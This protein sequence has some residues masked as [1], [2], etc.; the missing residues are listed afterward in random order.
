MT[1]TDEI[2]ENYMNFDED[3]RLK[4]PYGILEKL[5]T[6]ELI[7][8]YLRSKETVVFDIGA[9][10]GPYTTWLAEQGY[11]VHYSDI[12]PHHVSLFAEKNK[13]SNVKS[14]TIEDARKLSYSDE[15]AD[16]IILNGPLYHLTEAS[17][18]QAVLR[19]SLRILKPSGILLAFTISRLAGLN[20][21]LSSGD[22]FN[23]SYFD[24]VKGEMLTGIRDN[25]DLKNK[26]FISAYFHNQSEIE[27]EMRLAGFSDLKTLGVIGSAW[28]IPDLKSAIEDER[29]KE[30]LLEVARMTEMYPMLGP[31]MLTVGMKCT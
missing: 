29:K 6:Q 9:G 20:Y 16:L 17:E 25:R 31:K 11:Q 14:I 13:S 4:S 5:H 1:H 30:R 27:N 3:T 8:R 10:T 19:E 21:C 22:V 15:C 18:R 7:L 23:N 12:V 24:M 26:T 28:N 2:I